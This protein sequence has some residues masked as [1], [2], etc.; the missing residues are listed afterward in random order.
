MSMPEALT[1]LKTELSQ[2]SASGL[3]DL[4]TQALADA[5][6]IHQVEQQLWDRLLEL[7]HTCLAAFLDTHGTGD[8]ASISTEPYSPT[9]LLRFSQGVGGI[10][11]ALGR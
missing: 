8:L 11:V 3:I 2:V 4:L 10:R 6:P 9:V 7:G 1:I 5:T